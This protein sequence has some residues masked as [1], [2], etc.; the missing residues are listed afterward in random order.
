LTVSH[1]SRAELIKWCGADPEKISVAYLGSEQA[2]RS[3]PDPGVLARNRLRPYQ[4][5]LAVSSRNPSKN[6]PGLL[7]AIPY[8]AS[9]GVDVAIA[10]ASYAK[11]FGELDISG[12]RVHDLGYV[13]D[14]ELRSLYENAACFAF[15]SFY[16]GFGLPPLEALALGCPTVVANGNSLAEIFHGIAFLCDPHDPSDIA[17]KILRASEASEGERVRYREFAEGFRWNRCATIAWSAV[18][19]S[20]HRR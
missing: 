11:V 16:E 10:G 18:I 20:A 9:S 12:E 5:V 14:S 6:L 2:L 17:D 1:F 3:E 19:E 15:P 4:Y 7:R 13:D 8:L